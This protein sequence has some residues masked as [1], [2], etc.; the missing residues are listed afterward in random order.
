MARSREIVR[1]TTH[2]CSVGAP[3]IVEGRLWGDHR[4]LG[5]ERRRRATPRSAGAFAELLASR[6]RERRQ[7]RSAHRLAGARAHRRRRARAAGSC[8]TCTTARSS[9]SCTRS[10]TLKLAQR[11][12]RTKTRADAERSS[13]RR[14]RTRSRATASCASSPTGSSPP[15][16][17]AVVCGPA[18]TPS[19]AASTCRSA[20]TSPAARLRAEIE[21]SAYFIVAEA[22]TNVV[23]HAHAGRARC[24]VAW[25]TACCASR[26]ATT[27]SAARTRTVTGCSASPI[28]WPRCGGCRSG[29]TW[30]RTLVAASMPLAEAESTG[31]AR[32]SRRAITHACSIVRPAGVHTLAAQASDVDNR[33]EIAVKS[34][35]HERVVAVAETVCC[36]PAEAGKQPERSANS[37]RVVSAGGIGKEARAR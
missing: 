33:T 22:L 12:L 36:S 27:A 29:R 35:C 18:S 19:V 6:D 21:A 16:S 13:A 9:G 23:K 34:P 26:F 1:A 20:S 11:A 17:P 7:P 4:A 14:S 37:K 31:E 28:A 24:G 3:I 10:S 5:R 15:S 8:A 25:T 2:A 32:P 30:R